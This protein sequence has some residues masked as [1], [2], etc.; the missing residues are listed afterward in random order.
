MLI[1]LDIDGTLLNS[2]NTIDKE[3]LEIVSKVN[4]ENEIILTSARKP[5]ST[6]SIAHQLQIKEKIIVC[7]NGALIIEG[8]KKIL[9]YP[10]PTN[11]VLYIYNY[12]KKYNVSINIYCDDIWFAQT[13]D[14]LVLQE[15]QIVHEEPFLISN[16]LEKL[17]VHKILLIS[18][19]RELS[20]LKSRL[21]I[22]DNLIFCNSKKGYL[23]ITCSKANK[24][25]AFEFLLKYLS[26]DRSNTLAVGD[27]YND[28]E[29]LKGA[30]IGIAMGNA[31]SE[32]KKIAD[33]I[34]S[35]NDDNGVA[36]ALRRFL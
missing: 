17:T 14:D 24:K 2:N 27:G 22:L 12:A 6:K 20:F 28:I 3:T 9:E 31:P 25:N 23:E 4:L 18:H 5:S 32:V 30:Q 10:L 34:T 7:Y 21:S 33:Y 19:E 13:I 35:S 26:Y 29:L 1:F 11:E 36:Y 8:K 16:N 15:S